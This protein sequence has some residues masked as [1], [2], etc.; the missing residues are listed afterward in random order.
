MIAAVVTTIAEPTASLKKLAERL[1]SGGH[2]LTVVGDAKGPAEFSLPGSE[3]FSLKDQQRMPFVLSAILPV[4]H[5]TRKNVGYLCAM[6][7]SPQC[8]YET[9]DDNAPADSWQP[10]SLGTRAVPARVDGWFNAYR[11]FT[12]EFIWPRGLPLDQVRNGSV[13]CHVLETVPEDVKAPIQQGLADNSPDVDAV[14]RLL[15]DKSITFDRKPSVCLQPGT[16]CPFNSQSTW[17]WPRAYPLMYLPSYCSFRMTDIWRSFVAQ[18]CL[19]ELGYGVVFHAAEVYQERNPHDLMKDF[20]AEIPGYRGNQA[21]VDVLNAAS[22]KSGRGNAID[23]L[24]RCYERLI[25]AG[26]FPAREMELVR[27]WAQDIE[28]LMPCL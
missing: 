7:Q 3:F 10:R 21:F 24:V 12:D 16:W 25:E 19:W 1:A 8:L 26:F 4:G 23:N 22:L 28:L 5:Y 11:C 9:D 18:R 14:W 15:H 13:C 2:R 20:E 17:W 6:K 27:A